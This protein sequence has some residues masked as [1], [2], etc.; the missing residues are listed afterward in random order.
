MSTLL[1]DTIRKTG[2]SLGVD[3]RVKN[4]SVYESDGG[5]SV[6]LNLVQ[7]LIKV[8]ASVNGAAT[9]TTLDSYNVASLTDS[10]DG[11]VQTNFTSAFSNANHCT[12]AAIETEDGSN[13][14]YMYT[15]LLIDKSA[16]TT[17]RV[18]IN[19][20]FRADGSA[21]LGNYFSYY[22]QTTGDLA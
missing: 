7:G 1:T 16:E 18:E 13:V 5:T 17:S 10:A 3:I 22:H 15:Q 8:W 4:T 11:V 20:G 12:S 21:G 6:T 14:N 9:P 19:T 2:G